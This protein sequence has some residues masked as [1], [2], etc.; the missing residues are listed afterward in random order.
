MSDLRQDYPWLDGFSDEQVKAATHASRHGLVSAAPGSGK[1]KMVI[2]Y[3]GYLLSNKVKPDEVLGLAFNVDAIKEVNARLASLPLPN[4]SKLK[5]RTIHSFCKEVLQVAEEEGLL[6]VRQLLGEP[7]AATLARRALAGPSGNSGVY[8]VDELK[9][10]L[11]RQGLTMVK[12]GLVRLEQIDNHEDLLTYA[13]D[14]EEVAMAILEHERI[15][16]EEGLRTFDD[17]IF[18][19]ACLFRDSPAAAKWAGNEFEHII[20]DEYQDVDDAQQEVIIALL[21]TRGNLMVV[22]DEDQCIYG[23]R[24]ANLS[25]MMSGLEERLGKENV[26]RYQL[27]ETFRYGHEVAVAANSL[28]RNNED[29]PQKL[30]ISNTGTPRTSVQMRMASTKTGDRYW[31]HAIM[32]DLKEWKE[33]GRKMREAAVLVRT[34]EL[35]APLEMHLIREGVPYLIEGRGI[36]G[37]PEV[38]AINA[39]AVMSDAELFRDCGV[40]GRQ[41]MLASVL[42]SPGI[43]L[44]RPLIK[45]LSGSLAKLELGDIPKMIRSLTENDGIKPGQ[46]N[47]LRRRADVLERLT[48][49]GTDMSELASIIWKQ[50]D[51]R[52][53]VQ[54]RIAN[55]LKQADRLNVI[56]LMSREV[57]RY[58]TAGTM[59]DAFSERM[60]QQDQPEVMR[61]PLLIT[62]VHKSKGLEFPLVIVPGMIEGQFPHFMPDRPVDMESERRLAYVA[63]TRVKEKLILV[64]PNDLALANRWKIPVNPKESRTPEEADGITSRFLTEMDPAAIRAARTWFYGEGNHPMVDSLADYVVKVGAIGASTQSLPPLTADLT[65]A[66]LVEIAAEPEPAPAPEYEF[67][68]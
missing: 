68:F 54:R 46:L 41:E 16:Q 19:L 24:G 39:Y 59:L 48:A 50:L 33:S 1:T 49:A 11:L 8:D 12:A 7:E 23:W 18:D 25:Y 38:K 61:D 67:Q 35:A 21:G 20:V 37:M 55:P 30:C 26:T 53:D 63:Y 36:M 64:A 44:T 5:F 27:S 14:D 45:K 57:S 2:G 42:S 3:C 10:G 52:S 32:Q 43:F 51:W 28:I 4:A 65:V 15:R 31:P 17:L 62:S 58:E 9:V 13:E 56:N 29:R 34:Y 22:G 66:E 47:G 6:P 40:E 60:D